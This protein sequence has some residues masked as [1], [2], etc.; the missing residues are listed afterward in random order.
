[1]GMEGMSLRKSIL[2]AF[3]LICFTLMLFG[4]GCRKSTSLTTP[5]TGDGSG[6][7]TTFF[8]SPTGND[9][10]DGKSRQSPFKTLGHALSV[11]KPGDTIIILAGTYSESIDI[12]DLGSSSGTITIRGEDSSSPSGQQTQ[13]GMASAVFDGQNQKT[14]MFRCVRCENIHIENLEVR[15]YRTSA[16]SFW[17][18]KN[19]TIKNIHFKNVA[20]EPGDFV[21]GGSSAIVI[22]DNTLNA[23]VEGNI[24]EDSGFRN[25]QTDAVGE[26]I[27]CWR[28]F[29]STIRGNV[30]RNYIGDG[31]LIEE[32]CHTIVENNRIEQGLNLIFDWWTSAIWLDG[33]QGS[34]VRNNE[35]IQ[36]EGPGIQISDTE[37]EYKVGGS[38]NY[39]VE[40]NKISHNK[41]GVYIWNFGRCPPPDDVVEMKNNEFEGNSDGDV[42]CVEW[43]CGV[44]QSC[45]GAVATEPIQCPS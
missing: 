10:N 43:N 11:I 23:M 41:W 31:I 29:N 37:L 36:N 13:Y 8:V 12:T 21:E 25:S 14:I 4:A 2:Y 39:V 27:N 17:Q 6:L 1:M 32:A 22:A 3:G 35:I 44:N 16:I 15:N 26:L 18:S 33:G 7:G 38:R 19:V 45:T 5:D 9:Q 34:I 28:C 24:I 30:V 20:M 42:Y 40:G